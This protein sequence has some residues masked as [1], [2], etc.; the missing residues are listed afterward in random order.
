MRMISH[1]FAMK[2]N[3]CRNLCLHGICTKN[4]GLHS[5]EVRNTKGKFEGESKKENDVQKICYDI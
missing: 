3:I 4:L 1:K 5:I 2:Y